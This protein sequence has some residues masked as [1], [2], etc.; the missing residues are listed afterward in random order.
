MNICKSKKI[1]IT[2]IFC[3]RIAQN[4]TEMIP[5]Y[6]SYSLP[7]MVI[8]CVIVGKIGQTFFIDPHKNHILG[9]HGN[10]YGKKIILVQKV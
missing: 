4:F 8:I 3:G 2:Q 9:C 10:K 6:I 5:G 1:S 7:K